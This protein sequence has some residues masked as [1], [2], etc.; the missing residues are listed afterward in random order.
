MAAR[1]LRITGLLLV[2]WL[3]LVTA[4]MLAAP[5]T[6]A[7]SYAPQT[8]PG[9]IH[10]VDLNRGLEV[11]LLRVPNSYVV[12]HA[13]DARSGQ[14]AVAVNIG[15]DFDGVFDVWVRG[16]GR[17]L[18][19]HRVGT[20]FD[21]FGLSNVIW[22]EDA[23]EII[24]LR[25][26]GL[27]RLDLT[28]GDIQHQ[29]FMSGLSIPLQRLVLPQ[30]TNEVVVAV[31]QSLGDFSDYHI[32]DLQTAELTLA[33]DLPC[34]DKPRVMA[35]ALDGDRF[36]VCSSEMVIYLEDTTSARPLI[37]LDAFDGVGSLDAPQISPDGTHILFNYTTP[38]AVVSHEYIYRLS[39]G[40]IWPVSKRILLGT[41]V[42]WLPLEALRGGH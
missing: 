39:D 2:L 4:A 12:S 37:T 30:P 29:E 18:Q 9:Q 3:V 31:Q 40:Q 15:G 22:S 1:L 26:I 8:L 21:M 35:P 13:W 34:S 33:T 23:D 27:A 42:Q 41:T 5:P 14:L 19:R 20:S 6:L 38:T 11:P 7:V 25:A 32:L 24:L 28:T 10:A 17:T 16:P 36:Y